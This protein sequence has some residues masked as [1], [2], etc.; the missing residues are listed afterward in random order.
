MVGNHRTKTGAVDANLRQARPH[1]VLL[2]LFPPAHHR[3]LKNRETRRLREAWI[4]QA[5]GE[6]LGVGIGSG[7]NLKFYT[8]QVRRVYGVDPSVELQRMARNRA[9]RIDVEFL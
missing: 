8:Q 3:R 9:G 5:K 1:E 2:E 4:P 6:V 7:L